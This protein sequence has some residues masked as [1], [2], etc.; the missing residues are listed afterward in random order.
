MANS[1]SPTPAPGN[2]HSAFPL[3]G[4]DHAKYPI[5]VASYSIRLLVTGLFHIGSLRYK[6]FSNDGNYFQCSY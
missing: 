4:F 2:Q 6:L 5:D 1:P 3:C